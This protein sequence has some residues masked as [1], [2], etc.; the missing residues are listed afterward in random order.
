[1]AYET[2]YEFTQWC[3]NSIVDA[4]RAENDKV[5]TTLIEVLRQHL[6]LNLKAGK[7]VSQRQHARNLLKQIEKAQKQGLTRKLHYTGEKFQQEM[8][9]A[10][11]AY[12][13]WLRS[14]N[15][16]EDYITELII[17]KKEQYGN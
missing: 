16:P 2:L 8:K 5:A 6:S 15:Y 4:I 10:I 12:E 9:D 7:F 14:Q 3:Y 17:I 1:M 11:S 13:N